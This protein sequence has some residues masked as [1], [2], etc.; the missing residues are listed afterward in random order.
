MRTKPISTKFTCLT[1]ALGY[2]MVSGLWTLFSDKLFAVL[3]NQPS[4][5]EQSVG[6]SHWFFIAL[7]TGIL[8]WLLT[9]WEIAIAESHESLRKV[10]R[11][12]RS[13]SECTKAITR[14]D[15][16]LKLMEDIMKKVFYMSLP[17]RERGL[18]PA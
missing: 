3:L 10:N 4:L 18:N 16:E 13:F 14:A 8:Y 7:S 1:I 2:F 5:A 17:M 9:Y 6:P 15:D 12:L 11:S